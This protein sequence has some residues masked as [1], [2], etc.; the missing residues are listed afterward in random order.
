MEIIQIQNNHVVIYQ[1]ILHNH[2]Q[3]DDEL[4]ANLN[5]IIYRLEHSSSLLT[6]KRLILAGDIKCVFFIILNLMLY[7][8]HTKIRY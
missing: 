8:Y 7:V 6:I 5:E 1:Q 4:L 2:D 3:A